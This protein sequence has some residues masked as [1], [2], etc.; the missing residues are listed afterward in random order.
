[1]LLDISPQ[2]FVMHTEVYVLA[3]LI[4]LVHPKLMSTISNRKFVMSGNIATAGYCEAS[5]IL[6]VEYYNGAVY[7]YFDVS[8]EVSKKL[9][10]SDNFIE[11]FRKSSLLSK[12]SKLIEQLLPVYLG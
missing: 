4:D 10:S 8:I 6:A 3:S 12:Q 9:F 1:M 2:Y 5:K 11:E 7:H